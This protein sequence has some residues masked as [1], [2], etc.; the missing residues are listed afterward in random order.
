M[1]PFQE[2]YVFNLLNIF[3]IDSYQ[4]LNIENTGLPGKIGIGQKIEKGAPTIPC[5]HAVG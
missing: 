2:T 4:I 3:V 1:S 5:G